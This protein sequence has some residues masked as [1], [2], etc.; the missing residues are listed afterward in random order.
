GQLRPHPGP[1][2]RAGPLRRA[3]LRAARDGRAV[4]HV[5]PGGTMTGVAVLG[6]TGSIGTACLKVLSRHRDRFRVV[7]LTAFGQKDLL[8]TQA[9]SLQ[10]D[11]VG[12]V[13]GPANGWGG[14]SGSHCLVQAATH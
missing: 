2:R 13:P 9:R 14:A 11:Y 6:S 4:R 7:A 5:P 12:L 8:E 3:V 10:G 1:R